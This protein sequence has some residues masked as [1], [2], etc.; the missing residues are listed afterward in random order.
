MLQFMSDIGLCLL[1]CWT[2]VVLSWM[3]NFLPLP[4]KKVQVWLPLDEPSFSMKLI[5][6][7]TFVCKDLSSPF[8]LCCTKVS[9]ATLLLRKDPDNKV[10]KGSDVSCNNLGWG[11]QKMFPG[12]L[13]LQNTAGAF[14]DCTDRREGDPV[15][16]S[17]LLWRIN[18]RLIP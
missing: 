10:E 14:K 7:C 17:L 4:Q 11:V 2:V 8:L 13:V 3:W 6:A 5:E 16:R 18:K 1:E 15:E 9:L 12:P